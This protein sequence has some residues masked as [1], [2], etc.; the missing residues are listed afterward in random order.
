MSGSSQGERG[1][2]WAVY[3][4]E[5]YWGS[6]TR[7]DR[8]FSAAA[9]ALAEV[10]GTWYCLHRGGEFDED[11]ELL[12]WTSFTPQSLQPFIEALDKA[13]EP[14]SE[15]ATDEQKRQQYVE[16]V[17][18]AQRALGAAGEWKTDTRALWELSPQQRA[19][20]DKAEEPL[21]ADATDEQKLQHQEAVTAAEQIR[22]AA[23]GFSR[24]GENV[25]FCGEAPALVNDNGTLRMVFIPTDGSG[26]GDLSHSLWETSLN[27]GGDAPTWTLPEPIRT[28]PEAGSST[29]LAPGLAVFNG[30]VH[31][32]FVDAHGWPVS[33]L[34]RDAEGMWRPATRADGT[35]IPLPYYPHEVARA[36][37][38]YSDAISKAQGWSGNAALAV[39][40]GQ[41]HLLV[42]I[43]IPDDSE[44]PLRHLVFD[45]TAWTDLTDAGPQDADGK[46]V[47]L[48]SCR[49]A[50][51]AS[52]DGKLHALVAQKDDDLH[53]STW[54]QQTG[55]SKPHRAPWHSSTDAPALLPFKA[56]PADAER[57]VLL[58][59]HRGGPRSDALGR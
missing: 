12:L 52:H 22:R 29:P 21:P 40:D 5:E 3:V 59:I 43:E 10:D 47:T 42:R 26:S 28:P 7:F 9:P 56:G 20:L 27:T 57:E 8:H 49:G 2:K 51:L 36:D 46:K 37:P 23:R 53:H 54:T 18:A 6:P 39:H 41:L 58:M 31:L 19:T 4:A 48:V 1:L 34:V 15:D 25:I 14:L 13:S 33:H 11:L 32:V 55:W 30:A 16:S 44:L 45:G 35:N 50:A 17:E 24:D 38:Y